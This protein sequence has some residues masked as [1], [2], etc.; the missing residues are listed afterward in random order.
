LNPTF[1][2]LDQPITFPFK[3]VIDTIVLLK[4]ARTC[5]TPVETFLLPFALTIF[6]FSTSPLSSERLTFPGS[7]SFLA[8]G[9]WTRGAFAGSE[10]GV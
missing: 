7:T 2:A 5:A 1:P 3:S 9:F 10:D 6:G 4:V 8:L